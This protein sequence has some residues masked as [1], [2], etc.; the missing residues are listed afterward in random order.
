MRD[1]RRQAAVA[2]GPTFAPAGDWMTRGEEVEPGQAR[3]AEDACSDLPPSHEVSRSS[4]PGFLSGT[5]CRQVFGL[6]SVSDRGRRPYRP[7]LP[8]PEGPVQKV[9]LVLTYRCGAAPDF[10]RVPF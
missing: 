7:P 6:V 9:G 2:F 1:A 3:E 10:H 8:S 5:R 4:W